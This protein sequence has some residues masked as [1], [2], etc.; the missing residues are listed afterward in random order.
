MNRSHRLT[1][2]VLLFSCLLS[3]CG[4]AEMK[5]PSVSRTVEMMGTFVSVTLYGEN[6]SELEAAMNAAFA[7]AS[8]LEQCLSPSIAESEL[9]AVN[10]SAYAQET[11]VSESFFRLLTEAQQYAALSDGALDCTIGDLISLWGIG[12]ETARVPEASEIEA[13]LR[14]DSYTL[15]ATDSAGQTVRF[16]EEGVTLQ[17]GAV[18]K[19]YI[20]DEMKSILLEQ[21]V[22]SG[23]LV[24]GGNVLTIGSKPSG[25]AWKV[26]ITDPF[27]T[28]QLIAELTVSDLSVVTSGNYERYFE[29]DGV[30]Y[31]HIL[32]PETG[33][34][35]DSGLV[36]T[37]II[38]ASSVT[39]DA[40]STATYVLGA[41]EGMALIESLDGVEAVFITESGDILTSSGMDSY[42]FTKA[43]T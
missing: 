16:A 27:S 34:P 35:S 31:H 23:L 29:A 7:R 13:I 38:A 36:S 20:A 39:C 24:L 6:T 2:A 26:G 1:A 40:L 25:D 43:V 18:A 30:Q 15:V 22:E 3:G 42:H 8:E 14:K 10:E 11:P 17:F 12:T 33:Y 28:D 41:E 37:T 4:T 9:N 19:G 21:G 5:S 32:D